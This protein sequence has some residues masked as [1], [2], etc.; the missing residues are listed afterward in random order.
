MDLLDLEIGHKYFVSSCFVLRPHLGLRGARIDQGYRTESFANRIAFNDV[1]TSSSR[2]TC[3]FL[4]IGPRLGVDAEWRVGCGLSIFGQAA[5]SIVFG[6]NQRHAREEFI[7]S[8][9]DTAFTFA[10]AEY[11]SNGSSD[12]VSRAITDLSIGLKWEHCFEL[13]CRQHPFSL[14][15][16]WEHHGFYNFNNF[17]FRP[18]VS[19]IDFTDVGV[20]FLT[21]NI[22]SRKHGDLFTQGLTVSAEFGF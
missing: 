12:R 20:A 1:F 10:S 3:D 16:S 8:L 4:G 7:N 9:L 17:D 15:F 6:K 11:R 14:A 13:C 5:A 22:G 19:P 18:S 2:S 21:P